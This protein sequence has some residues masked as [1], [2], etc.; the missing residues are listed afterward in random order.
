MKFNQNVNPSCEFFFVRESTHSVSAKAWHYGGKWHW[1]VYAYVQP[2]HP[3]Y[4]DNEALQNLPFNGGCTYDAIRTVQPFEIKYDFQSLTTTKIVGSD[5][6][7][8]FDNYDHHP[9]PF[10]RIPH[11]VLRDARELAQALEVAA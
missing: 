2:S 8:I 6:A 1:N 7:H 3:K 9:S 10:E 5:Y 11:E 4:D